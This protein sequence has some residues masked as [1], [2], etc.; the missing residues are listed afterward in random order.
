LAE[1]FIL[2][3][4]AVR[5]GPGGLKETGEIEMSSKESIH[6]LATRRNSASSNAGN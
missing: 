2:I 3:P 5:S 6:I 1:S 4:E